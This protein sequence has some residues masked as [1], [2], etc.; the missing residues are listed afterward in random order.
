M[1]VNRLKKYQS[2]AVTPREPVQCVVDLSAIPPGM[3][4]STLKTLYWARLQEFSIKELSQH[5]GVTAAAMTGTLDT[6]ESQH[7]ASRQPHRKDRRKVMVRLTEDG[8]DL[9]RRIFP[10]TPALFRD[11]LV[12]TD[13]PRS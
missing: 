1:I 9:A 13:L 8:R 2:E 6:M 3:G 5:L 11:A 12:Q 10:L 7:W 4:G